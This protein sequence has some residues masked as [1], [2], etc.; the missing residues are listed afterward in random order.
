VK[1][2]N[3]TVEN[4]QKL[5]ELL[6]KISNVTAVKIDILRRGKKESLFVEII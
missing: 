1:I 2:N 6:S 3:D 4:P 5:L